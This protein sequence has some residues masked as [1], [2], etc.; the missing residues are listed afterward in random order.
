MLQ[1]H[2]T[3]YLDA[4]SLI[5]LLEPVATFSIVDLLIILWVQ[6]PD[7]LLCFVIPSL[8]ELTQYVTACVI[9]PASILW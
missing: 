3:P 8:G 9:A 6:L 7:S 2:F 4:M 1:I 5:K